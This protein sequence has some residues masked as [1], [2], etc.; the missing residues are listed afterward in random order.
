ME[1]QIE[2]INASDPSVLKQQLEQMVNLGWKIKGVINC[3]PNIVGSEP[4]VIMERDSADDPT[5]KESLYDNEEPITEQYYTHPE[6]PRKEV[7]I[8]MG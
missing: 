4:F 8:S 7:C 3:N 2:I 1:K 5:I 6:P